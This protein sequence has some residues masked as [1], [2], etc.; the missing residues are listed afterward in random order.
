MKPQAMK[1]VN[2]VKDAYTVWSDA[3]APTLGAALS[4]YTAFSIAPFMM[5]ALAVAGMVFGAEAANEEVAGEI[6]HIVGPTAAGAI[7]EVL[8]NAENRTAGT[9]AT[10]IGFALLLFSASGVFGELQNALNTIWQVKPQPNAGFLG[11]IRKRF[12]SFSMVLGTCFIL[13]VSLG[14]SAA[15]EAVAAYWTPSSLPGGAYLWLAIN[16]VVSLAVVTLLFAMIYKYLPDVDIAWREVWI[17]ALTTA[18]LFVVGKFLLGLYLGRSGVASSYGAAGSLVLFLLW[19]Y[20][21]AQIFLFGASLT[22][23]YAQRSRGAPI[24]APHFH[25]QPD[26]PQQ[27]QAQAKVA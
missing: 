15:L 4:Y 18:V 27:T 22:Y 13:L 16:H 21:S 10:I 3:K 20:Y 25:P 9:F 1:V 23:V 2:Y 17:G 6:N 5:I 26:Q 7:Q 8:K 11:T 14:V 24:Q 19:V 12:L